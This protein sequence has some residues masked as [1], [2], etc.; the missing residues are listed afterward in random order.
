MKADTKNLIIKDKCKYIIHYSFYQRHE[1][2]MLNN[3]LGSNN[4]FFKHVR[5]IIWAYYSGIIPKLINVLDNFTLNLRIKTSE[6]RE[7]WQCDASDVM[8]KSQHWSVWKLPGSSVNRYRKSVQ[9]YNQFHTS[10]QRSLVILSIS[11]WSIGA[12]IIL[13]SIP[14]SFLLP[15]ECSQQKFFLGGCWWTGGAEGTGTIASTRIVTW[16]PVKG[17][18]AKISSIAFPEA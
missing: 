17:A 8:S 5:R 16:E 7:S 10:M 14:M 15:I 12:I 6:S 13:L 9:I 4:K 1:A 11:F 3:I 2:G 18:D